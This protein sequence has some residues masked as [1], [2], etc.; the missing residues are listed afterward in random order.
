MKLKGIITISGEIRAISGISIGGSTSALNANVH[1]NDIIQTKN[2][3][4][5]IS[6]NSLKGKMRD[7]LARLVGTLTEEQDFN[8]DQT[9]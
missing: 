4:P 7:M 5:Y 8:V 3:V 9:S 6:G 2:G 1:E